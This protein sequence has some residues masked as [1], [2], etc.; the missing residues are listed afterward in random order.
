[1]QNLGEQVGVDTPY[2]S[3]VIRLASLIMDRDYL[4]E[5]KRTMASLGLSTLTATELDRLLA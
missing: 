1:M 3:A 4:G 5:A 2:I